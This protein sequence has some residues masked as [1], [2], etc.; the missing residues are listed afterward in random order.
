M[1]AVGLAI[2]W[3]RELTTCKPDYYRWNQWLFLKMLE[4]GIAYKK[5]GVVNW[6]PVD[7]TVLANEQVI[8]GRGWRS[9]APVERREI[10]MYYLRITDYADELLDNLDK[11]TGWPERVR[12][13]QANWIGRSEGVR[14]A[15]PHDIRASDGAPIGGG[16]LWVFTTRADTIMGITF[17]AVAADHPLAAH[18]ALSDPKVAAFIDECRHGSTI[19]AEFAT[20][21]KKGVPTGHHVRHP[22]TGERI[23][24]WVGNYVLMSYGEGAVMGVPGHDERDFAFAKKYQLPIKQVIA[25]GDG[26]FS[27]DTW[28]PWYEDKARGVCIDSGKFNGMT[29]AQAVAAIVADL[30]ALGLGEKR[31]TYRLRDWG[32]SRQRYWGTP[33]PIVHCPACGDVPVPEADLPVVL[34]EDC[35]PGRNRQSARQDVPI[36]S[37]RHVPDAA[38]PQSAKPT[39]WIR[40]S[41][42]RGTTCATPVPGADGPWSTRVTNTGTRWTST[43]GAS[44]TPSCTFSMHASGPR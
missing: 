11:M 39:R 35:V 19:E 20:M 36:S 22:L 21:E 40:S 34:P 7:Q 14:F 3:S 13:M 33:I 17:C 42:R 6:D 18:A 44:S 26:R 5:T 37:T 8:D 10:P 15:F 2:D 9:G 27:A 25:V 38:A 32:I 24:I 28:Q 23:E 30:S 16:R 43:S 1:Q 31:I 4:R 12:A 41:T 29:Y